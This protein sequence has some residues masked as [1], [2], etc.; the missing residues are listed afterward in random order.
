MTLSN[1]GS[2]PTVFWQGVEDLILKLLII[3][4]ITW[5]VI[6]IY[7][8]KWLYCEVML[9]F[10]TE[11]LVVGSSKAAKSGKIT[12]WGQQFFISLYFDSV[13]KMSYFT[14]LALSK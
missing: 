13:S 11:F 10:I 7:I 12:A 6:Y 9:V 3:V 2:V 14:H 1:G 4:Q 5:N 8:P